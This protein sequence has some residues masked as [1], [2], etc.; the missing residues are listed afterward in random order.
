MYQLDRFFVWG[1]LQNPTL[2]WL[3]LLILPYSKHLETP[4]W[5]VYEAFLDQFHF[6]MHRLGLFLGAKISAK[7]IVNKGTFNCSIVGVFSF[8]KKIIADCYL[9]VFLCI[10][11]KVTKFSCSFFLLKTIGYMCRW[12]KLVYLI[13]EEDIWSLGTLTLLCEPADNTH[14]VG[15]ICVFLSLHPQSP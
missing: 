13:L 8:I 10:L 4:T 15:L 9:W 12:R 5:H 11:G 6:L 3:E 14:E 2:F 7:L 1:A